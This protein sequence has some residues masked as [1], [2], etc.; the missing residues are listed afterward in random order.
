MSTFVYALANP[1]P[2]PQGQVFKAI[3]PS[4]WKSLGEVSV[5]RRALKNEGLSLSSGVERALSTLL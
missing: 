5:S 4:V 3:I 1:A 2:S